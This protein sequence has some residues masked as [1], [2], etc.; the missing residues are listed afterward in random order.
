MRRILL[1]SALAAGLALSL[2]A[3]ALDLGLEATVKIESSDNIGSVNA[4]GEEVG[5][6][7]SVLLGVFGEQRS[8]RLQ[9]GFAGDLETSLVVSDEDAEPTTLNNFYGAA[10]LLLTQSF[11]WYFG[12]VLGTIQTGPGLLSLNEEDTASRRNVF[13]TGPS[14]NYE[15]DSYSTIDAQVLYFHQS[16]DARDLAQLLNSTFVW[17][18]ETD[19]GNAFGLNINNIYTD[20]PLS[21][22][23]ED[24][25]EDNNRFSASAFWE[26][27]RGRMS[28][29]AAA[30]ATRYD[31]NEAVING[32]NAEF[33]LLR[34]L[35]PVAELT[36]GLATDLTDE[37]ISTIDSLL[38]DGT[39][40]APE[41]AGVFQRHSASL[42]YSLASNTSAFETGIRAADSQ[43]QLL[44]EINT[45][46]DPTLEDNFSVSV[47][48]V[49]SRQITPRINLEFGL[50]FQTE[51]FDNREDE[52]D[53][54]LASAVA[55]FQLSQ[56]FQLSLGAR[57]SRTEGIDT[58][59]LVNEDGS[60]KLDRI[61]NRVSLELQWAPP[62]RAKQESVV[63]LKQLLR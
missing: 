3:R 63:Q 58:R 62:S 48:G 14:F 6:V 41:A 28:W 33:R 42:I 22:E 8:R 17:T 15:I 50:E 23:G 49:G 56:S 35:S 34:R 30:G 16:E 43:Y 51:Q 13:V 53:S 1:T 20:E 57:T 39:G 54:V 18:Q 10:N 2:H 47:F 25:D 9:A 40:D 36:F 19:G 59:T 7:G 29:Y 45:A 44:S 38:D 52:S 21:P 61:E 31:V 4:G 60:N 55:S 26:R 11:S 27:D 5:Q 12:D 24:V 32:A 37:N 46:V